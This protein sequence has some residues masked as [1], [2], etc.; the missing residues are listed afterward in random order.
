MKKWLFVLLV[1]C[2]LVHA[3]D[4]VPA[5]IIVKGN[6]QIAK[7]YLAKKQ[8]A[9]HSVESIDRD[10]YVLR[11]QENSDVLH[12]ANE[13]K[14][15]NG[16]DFA[17]VNWIHSLRD[18]KPPKDTFWLHQWGMS[19]IG[20]DSPSGAQ[21]TAGAD[22]SVLKAWELNKG[23]RDVIVGV[24]DTGIDYTH[25]DL[26]DNIWVNEK[27]LKGVDGKDDDGNGYTD[28]K[29]GWNFITGARKKTYHGQ[30]GHPDP[31][32]DNSH[33]THCAGVIGAIPNNYKGV[34]GINWNVKLMALKF[35]SK[36][37]F[38]ASA[39]AYR[40]ILYALQNNVDVLSNSWGGGDKDDLIE[41]AIQKAK[42]S[43]V[44]FVAAAGNSASNNDH[45]PHYP[46][47]YEV[48]NVVSVA[49]TDNKDQIA[50]FSNY[51]ASTVHIAAPG[52]SI[53]ST[54]PV[55]M[56]SNKKFAY[57]AYSGTS[58][59]TP[60]VAGAAALLIAHDANLRKKPMEIKKRLLS[61]VDVLPQLSG[62]VSSQGRLNVH[63]ALTNK[64]NA[65]HQ[66]DNVESKDLDITAPRYNEE[67]FDKTWRIAEPEADYVRVHFKWLVADIPNFD[68]IAIYD[69]SYRLIFKVEKQYPQ[70]FWTPW[71]KG[72]A[73]L[74]RFAN[75]L[76]AIEKSEEREFKSPDEGFRA[77]AIV[78]MQEPS[79]KVI[80]Y[81]P[82]IS[83]PFAN[84]ESAG[85]VIDKIEYVKAEVKKDEE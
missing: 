15:L 19:N 58:M 18:V 68:F 30:L 65:F 70:G 78:C 28:D 8:C 16:I 82:T 37:G 2:V 49:A 3:K 62:L 40:A 46:S 1:S 57:A 20:Q 23:S 5:Q 63:S 7:E 66:L 67:L 22:I 13:I 41:Y 25:P 85:F 48:D 75:A 24:I 79:G 6:L 35:L 38:G 44:L 45:F 50:N 59:A 32:D 10:I 42:N 12:M 51:G 77:G 80:C 27:E 69:K 11:V 81:I 36:E 84:F 60:F 71:I 76:V 73:A 55:S 47:N 53:M 26:K 17:Q 43:G 31:M 52:V 56:S 61:T 4:Y 9:L 33:G 39:D 83:E 54:I 34:A 14:A 74:V 29:Y 64:V 72:D 21:G